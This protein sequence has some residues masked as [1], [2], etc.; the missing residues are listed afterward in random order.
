MMTPLTIAIALHNNAHY[1]EECLSSLERQSLGQMEVLIIDDGSTDNPEVVIQPFLKRN[2]TW[3]LLTQS[4]RG[5]GFTRNRAVLLARGEYVGFLDSDDFVSDTYCRDLLNIAKEQNA[6]MVLS[7]FTKFDANTGAEVTDRKDQYKLIGGV[8]KADRYSMIFG[9]MFGLAC[10]SIFRRRLVIENRLFFPSNTYHEDLFVIPRL[11]AAAE[12]IGHCESPGYHWRMRP[13]SESH[14]INAR[15]VLSVLHALSEQEHVLRN[16]AEYPKFRVNFTQHCIMYLNGLRRRIESSTSGEGDRAYL[17][18][19]LS[20]AS[21]QVLKDKTDVISRFS[22]VYPEMVQFFYDGVD[23]R[24]PIV[25]SFRQKPIKQLHCDIMMFP[26]KRYHTL[27]MLP[28][29]HALTDLGFSCGFCD[30][31]AAYGDEAAFDEFVPGKFPVFMFDEVQARGCTYSASVFMNDWDVKCALPTISKDNAE[32]RST[33]GIVEG[34]QDFWDKDTGRH[35][36]AYQSVRYLIAAGDHDLRYFSSGTHRDVYIG[37]V[38]RIS[39]LLQGEINY[40]SQPIALINSNFTYGVLESERTEFLRAASDAA[41]AEGF[42]PIVTRHPQDLG[43]LSGFHVTQADMYQAIAGASVLIS[44]FSSAI[45]EA[46]AM[47]KP[48]IYFNPDIERVDKFSEP[49]GAFA[50]SNT[51]ADLRT[52]LKEVRDNIALRGPVGM[53]RSVRERAAAFLHHHCGTGRPGANPDGIADFIGRNVHVIKKGSGAIEEPIAAVKLFDGGDGFKTLSGPNLG[54]HDATDLAG[55]AA[56][57]LLDPQSGRDLLM[58]QS[59]EVQ[60]AL[61][62]L[63]DESA[64]RRHFLRVKEFIEAP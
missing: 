55:L 23:R 6:C 44:R 20:S 5:V 58:K 47:G 17:Y 42:I 18:D 28:I 50:V 24:K 34:I 38:P 60:K 10:A 27:T 32:G 2:K 39:P 8:P 25:N 35:R 12:I 64:I 26:H 45:I 59:D 56:R 3:R 9:R 40:P 22:T 37:G 29:A 49:Q 63:P 14:S 4:N 31:S 36:N 16:S 46:L 19:L 21:Q 7:N 54:I 43:D 61:S 33:F 48:A 53:G 51:E 41:T 62:S 30:M 52:A 57:L 15:H 11:Y 13:G 1:I